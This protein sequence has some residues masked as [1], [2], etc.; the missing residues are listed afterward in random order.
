MNSPRPGSGELLFYLTAISMPSRLSVHYNAQYKDFYCTG[1]L[2]E[3]ATNV[4]N[5]NIMTVLK[6]LPCIRSQICFL[7]GV[8]ILHCDGLKRQKRAHTTVGIQLTLSTLPNEGR[9][10]KIMC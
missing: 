1:N 2:K 3:T 7:H 5:N 9:N 8:H 10:E 6:S 4:I